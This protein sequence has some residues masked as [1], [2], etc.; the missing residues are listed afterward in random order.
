MT[1]RGLL[2]L[3][4]NVVVHV[5]RGKDLGRRIDQAYGLRGSPER[6]LISVVTVGEALALGRQWHWGETKMAALRDLLAEFVVVDISHKDVLE[7]YADI[8]ARDKSGGWNLS[9]NDTWIAATAAVTDALLL[10]TDRDFGRVDASILRSIYIDPQ[11][12]GP[13]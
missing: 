4:T 5:G 10:T 12:P 11:T 6:P 8:R 2:L 3:D 9:H 13:A 1:G 7:R